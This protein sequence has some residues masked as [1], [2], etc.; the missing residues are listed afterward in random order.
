MHV[1]Q[2]TCCMSLLCNADA[3]LKKHGCALGC[4]VPDECPQ[5]VVDL[6]RACIAQ[7][8]GTRPSA[9]DVQAALEQLLPIPRPGQAEQSVSGELAAT[10]SGG[11]SAPQPCTPPQM[12]RRAP[13]AS[14]GV[15]EPPRMQQGAPGAVE[16]GMQGVQSLAG[17]ASAAAEPTAAQR[18]A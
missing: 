8:P 16:E 3:R 7:D 2:Y 13:G 12:Q 6:F 17:A 18:G 4:R 9:A 11:G 15:P 10:S 14:G 1:D 5:G